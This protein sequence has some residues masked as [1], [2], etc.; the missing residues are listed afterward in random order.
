MK[1]KELISIGKG[2]IF[3]AVLTG[4]TATASASPALF[5]SFKR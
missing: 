5:L 1:A 2:D 4:L 3:F